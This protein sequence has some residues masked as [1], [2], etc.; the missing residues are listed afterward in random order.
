MKADP[1]VQLHQQYKRFMQL[2]LTVIL[3]HL[4]FRGKKYDN[5][6]AKQQYTVLVLLI[7]LFY[8]S[9]FVISLYYYN[10]THLLL[11]N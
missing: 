10:Y 4:V 1:P 5:Y 8:R 11:G 6:T 2:K 9:L 7:S 3:I